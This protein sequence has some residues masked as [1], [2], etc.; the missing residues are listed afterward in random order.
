[1][2]GNTPQSVIKNGITCCE[3]VP[4][5]YVP[6]LAEDVRAG[7]IDEP[8]SL[9]PKYFYDAY[10]SELFEKICNTPEYYATRTEDA[11]LH[12]HSREIIRC[13]R[14]RQI[15]EFGSG[16]SQKTRRLFDACQ[17]LDHYCDYAPFE[18]C[19]ETL[20]QASGELCEEYD[21]LTV[22]P[23][24]GDYHAGLDNL[25]V[26]NEPRLFVFLG[27]TIGNFPY[28]AAM[29][30][31]KEIQ[32]QMNAGDFL[33]IGADRIKA[34]DVL[35]AAYNDQQGLTAKFNLN[36]LDVINRELNADFSLD[37]F[38]HNAGFNDALARIEMRLT[39][40]RNQ[41]VN[42][43]GLDEIVHFNSG[44]SIL[45]EISQKYSYDGI[46]KLLTSAGLKVRRHFES[47]NRYFSLL[48]AS[49]AQ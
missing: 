19:P 40:T 47:D 46:E 28:D 14:P 26:C 18:Y 9:P 20:E 7:L 23:L 6:D 36:V 1:M 25:P 5:R 17:Q 39:A 42:I 16:N 11:L 31:L 30:F 27:S 3:V 33:L 2:D 45:T 48:L 32:S 15:L 12:R 21:W 44:D 29:G 35:N 13:I 24:L 49:A 34:P 8:R 10:G 41:D 38:R 43:A 22:H 4:T 37:G